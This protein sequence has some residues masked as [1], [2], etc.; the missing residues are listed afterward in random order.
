MRSLRN[1]WAHLHRSPLPGWVTLS[2]PDLPDRVRENPWK[3]QRPQWLIGCGLWAGVRLAA[4]ADN[5]FRFEVGP[6]SA[7]ATVQTHSPSLGGSSRNRSSVVGTKAESEGK[8]ICYP[9]KNL[10]AR[11]CTKEYCRIKLINFRQIRS[12]KAARSEPGS[13]Q[14]CYIISNRSLG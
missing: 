7:Y 6:G 5:T 11:V 10:V 14:T 8:R 12:Y 1:I 4:T 2:R 9:M 13:A 3:S